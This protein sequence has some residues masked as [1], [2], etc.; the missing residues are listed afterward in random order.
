MP[1]YQKLYESGELAQRVSRLEVRLKECNIC[2]RGCG[3]NRLT[4]GV[5][6][7]NSGEL[8]SVASYCAHHGE[9]PPLSADR[10]SGTIFFG[11]C[12]LR[13]IFCQNHQISQRPDLQKSNE[14]STDKLAEIMLFLQNERRCHNINLVSPSQFAPQILAALCKA[15]PQGLNLPLVYN[16]NGYDSVETLEELEGVVDIYLPDIKYARD[17]IAER[18]SEAPQYVARNRKAI[19]EMWRQVG[20]L[21]VNG[22]GVAVKGLIIRHLILPNGLSGSASSLRWL[23]EELSPTVTISLMSQYS[24]R[25][26]AVKVKEINRPVNFKEY[27][28][29]SETMERLGLTRGWKQQI[30]ADKIYLPDFDNKE[31]PFSL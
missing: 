9:E 13:C 27:E 15:I 23:A 31:K 5:G 8:P 24:P 4:G 21:E 29:A 16:S 17:L 28:E 18:L 1:H 22:S 26:H 20:E 19:K 7:C 12:N 14:V 3:V 10:G 2:P 6:F 30:G 25:H 11:N